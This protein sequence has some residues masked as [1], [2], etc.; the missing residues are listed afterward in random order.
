MTPHLTLL[1]ICLGRHCP[2]FSDE[3]TEAQSREALCPGS[4]MVSSGPFWLQA[5][6]VPP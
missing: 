4:Q 2:Q 3:K 1:P 5:L 6:T